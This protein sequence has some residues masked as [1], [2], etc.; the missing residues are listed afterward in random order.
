MKTNNLTPETP[1]K[2][3]IMN[4]HGFT[5]DGMIARRS[6]WEGKYIEKNTYDDTW[7]Y[8]DFRN[9]VYGI[10]TFGDLEKLEQLINKFNK[11][12]TKD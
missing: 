7:T 11:N 2:E 8:S 10:K 3:S 4:E 1:L 9:R 6:D 5:I 12:E